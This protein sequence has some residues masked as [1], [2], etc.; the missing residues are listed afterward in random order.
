ML[1]PRQLE[2]PW[3]DT[4]T[5][6]CSPSFLLRICDACMHNWSGHAWL[7]GGCLRAWCYHFLRCATILPPLKVGYIWHYMYPTCSSGEIYSEKVAR[8]RVLIAGQL[9]S[10][11][12]NSFTILST[13]LW[14]G[15]LYVWWI[16]SH[17][18]SLARR[19]A[20]S[21][22]LSTIHPETGIRVI[23]VPKPA[24]WFRNLDVEWQFTQKQVSDSLDAR[25][26]F[27]VSSFKNF[28][29]YGRVA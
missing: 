17:V 10:S 13:Q 27:R 6:G 19:E 3:G 18:L 14:C 1:T 22:S 24:S 9:G 28:T 21:S 26:P 29:I 7:R 20:G 25:L 16:T 11:G 8:L 5:S 2:S 23:R 4:H 15:W 12:D